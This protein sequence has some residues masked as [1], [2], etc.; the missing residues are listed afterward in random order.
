MPHRAAKS[1]SMLVLLLGVAI[2]SGPAQAADDVPYWASIRAT[3]VNM[4][5]GPGED[6]KIK[7]TYRRKAL[8]MKVVR[9]MDGWRLVED[10]DGAQG[11]MLARFLSRERAAYVHGKGLA[12]M[13][14]SGA[15]NARLLW[16]IE[17]GNVGLLGECDNGW[18]KLDVRGHVGFVRQE[19]LWGAGEP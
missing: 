3:V 19:R 14:E 10:P 5:V 8:P 7:W 13:R 1:L 2:A 15:A 18:C 4:R 16:R 6:Y 17:P 9:T 11:W 12:E